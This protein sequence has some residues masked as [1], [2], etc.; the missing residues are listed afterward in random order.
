MPRRIT[1][2]PPSR[3][4]KGA[5]STVPPATAGSHLP[6]ASPR[7]VS[8][9]PD[10]VFLGLRLLAL[11]PPS[12]PCA[13]LDD[14]VLREDTVPRRPAEARPH[15]TLRRRAERRPVSSATCDGQGQADWRFH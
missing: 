9:P 8:Q 2:A 4:H 13:N 12:A 5:G 15:V 14:R 3:F 1:H 7:A 10:V 11:P 6:R